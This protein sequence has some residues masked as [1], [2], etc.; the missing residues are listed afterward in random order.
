M[1]Y[2]ADVQLRSPQHLQQVQAVAAGLYSL[3]IFSI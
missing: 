3:I 2:Q 1:E